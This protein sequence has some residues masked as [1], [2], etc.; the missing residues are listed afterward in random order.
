MRGGLMQTL[1]GQGHLISIH[2]CIME[3]KSQTFIN[4]I[5]FLFLCTVMSCA[6]CQPVARVDERFELTSIA[7]RLTNE[8]ILVH[9]EPANYMEDIDR[10][11]SQYKNH[12]LVD[13]IKSHIIAH[14][15]KYGFSIVSGLAADVEIT[16]KGIVYTDKWN[17]AYDPDKNDPQYCLTHDELKEYLRLLN[18]FYKD[19]RFHSFYVQHSDFYRNAEKN[20]LP[21]IEQIDTAWFFDFFGKPSRVDN[22]W[23]VP[24]NGEFNFA[25]CHYTDDGKQYNDIALGCTAVDSM[26]Y[27]TFDINDFCTLVH[28]ICHNYTQSLLWTK[29]AEFQSI[30]DSL[31]EYEYV[32]NNLPRW[33]YGT[34][35]TILVEGLN[36][37]CE[38]YYYKQHN[39]FEKDEMSM[40]IKRE[41]YTGF[42]W[43]SEML[44]FTD[45]FVSNRNL[46]PHFDDFLPQL[47]G[48]LRQVNAN[49]DNY[50]IPKMRR[51]M[52]VS[53]FPANG[54]VV[55]TTLSEV[56]IV[57]SE[58][59]FT[60]L[61]WTNYPQDSA[62]VQPLPVDFD[63]LYWKDDR[64]YV[65]PLQEPLKRH[66]T[67]GFSLSPNV[68]NVYRYCATPYDLIFETK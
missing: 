30:C 8:D 26:G 11:F 36:R 55:D 65:I 48:F 39:T 4:A 49:M 61:Y 57:F 44:E 27:P 3:N 58:S 53:T 59:M 29:V 62:G 54:T 35:S 63:N 46:Y 43:F 20:L 32:K 47:K 17:L 24:A 52:V 40:Q 60:G 22:I 37:L 64:T 10:Y 2:S 5:V 51:P 42:I 13:F 14:G 21:W 67:Y 19:T 12:E 9:S 6:L 15:D 7:F 33:G 56:V 50:Y 28:E 18:K 23:L 68:T 34:S 1:R 25:L 31:F 41:E 66:T 38:F 16:P 45:A